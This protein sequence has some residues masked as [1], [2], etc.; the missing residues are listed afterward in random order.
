MAQGRDCNTIRLDKQVRA[1]ILANVNHPELLA[2]IFTRSRDLAFGRGTVLE[3]DA[4]CREQPCVLWMP[5]DK[6]I[7]HVTVRVS[8][9][10]DRV[11]IHVARVVHTIVHVVPGQG[12]LLL[13]HEELLHTCGNNGQAHNAYGTC[14]NPAHFAAGTSE[15][16]QAL[17]QARQ[18]MRSLSL[19]HVAVAQ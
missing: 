19:R 9:E 5:E 12:P 13:G 8:R 2:E 14:L 10:I 4:F 6:T 1:E 11:L 17:R 16:R 18:L 3:F 15:N 7:R